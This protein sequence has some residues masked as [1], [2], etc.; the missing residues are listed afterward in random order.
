MKMWQMALG[1]W[2][3]LWGLANLIS[4][5]FPGINVVLGIIALICGILVL[6]DR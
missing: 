3:I 4:L 2:L 5:A 6:I 1:A